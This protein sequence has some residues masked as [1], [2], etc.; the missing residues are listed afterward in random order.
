[1]STLL[2]ETNAGVWRWRD[3]IAI[4]SLLATAVGFY[5][6]FRQL[7]K[8]RTAS[9]AAAE[10][11]G[12]T[13]QRLAAN[14]FLVLLPQVQLAQAELDH[15]IGSGDIDGTERLLMRWRNLAAQV[16]GLVEQLVDGPEVVAKLR[17]SGVLATQAKGVL[18]K[19]TQPMHA[20]TA[21][22]A[23]SVA[24]ACSDLVSIGVGLSTKP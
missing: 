9:E 20:V 23:A 24:E 19:T 17:E 2:A 13:A 7:R 1:M 22:V 18:R 6:A 5:I 4:V 12:T 15:V 10:A 16:Q 11:V 8:T 21:K 3:A 14:Q